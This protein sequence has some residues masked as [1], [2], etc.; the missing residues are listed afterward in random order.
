MTSLT[1][2]SL[3]VAVGL[4][5]FAGAACGEST[6][7]AATAQTPVTFD[8]GALP[9]VTSQALGAVG[10]TAV[11]PAPV[12][13][14]GSAVSSAGDQSPEGALAPAG[15]VTSRS[16]TIAVSGDTLMHRPLV[17]EARDDAGGSGYDFTPMFARIA[18]LVSRADLAICHLETPVAP[19]G[20][21]LS[22]FPYY[23]VPPEVAAGLA[24]AG[25]DRCSTASNHTFDRGTDGI[26]ATIAALTANGIAES[27]MASDPNSTLPATFVVNGVNVAHL[28]YTFSYNGIHV[29]EADRWR[30]NLI[31]PGRMLVDAAAVRAAGAEY[32]IVSVHAGSEGSAI[33]NEQ[34]RV[35][36]DVLTASGMVDLVVGHHAHVLQPIEQVNGHW[37]LFGL[38]NLISNMPTDPS[39]PR[40][41]QDG[42][43]V[44]IT[45]SSNSDGTLVTEQP[46][47]MPTW[48]QHGDYVIRSVLDDLADPAVDGALRDEVEA[49]LARTTKVLGRYLATAPSP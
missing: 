31:D 43:I 5:A 33:P 13:A 41:T 6:S 24:S 34:Q 35:V 46:V 27:G 36:A 23:G 19:D 17:N 20:E 44:L 47:V 1:R 9:T 28:S 25:Y 18:P 48:M 10:P 30:S 45:V 29:P 40:S 39:W 12:G 3:V 26:D 37:V 22:T 2:R 16:F 4:T 11:A 42:A 32:V 21:E 8:L 14:A 49:S 15:A 38:G 7:R